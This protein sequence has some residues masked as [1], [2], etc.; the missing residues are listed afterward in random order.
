MLLDVTRFS[1]PFFGIYCFGGVLMLLYGY[2]SKKYGL[3]KVVGPALNTVANVVFTI[4]SVVCLR[5]LFEISVM[6]WCYV[7]ILA[8]IH[9]AALML[10]LK[11]HMIF[12]KP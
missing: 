5:I 1:L 12:F 4:S 7:G 8:V 3:I 9:M 6:I 2:F 10:V 11:K